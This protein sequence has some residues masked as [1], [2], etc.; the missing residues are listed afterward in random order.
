MELDIF[1]PWG[2][3]V[4]FYDLIIR[5]A[6]HCFFVPSSVFM[7]L[8]KLVEVLCLQEENCCLLEFIISIFSDA[9]EANVL[10]CNNP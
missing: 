6:D 5:L 1:F 3:R 8:L 10:W 4:C 9:G 2:S 7:I